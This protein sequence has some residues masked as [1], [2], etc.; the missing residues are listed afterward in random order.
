MVFAANEFALLVSRFRGPGGPAF[1]GELLAQL[2]QHVAARQ[3][4]EVE[5]TLDALAV[6]VGTELCRDDIRKVGFVHVVDAARGWVRKGPD[7]WGRP[8]GDEPGGDGRTFRHGHAVNC[9]KNSDT[10]RGA[11]R[12]NSDL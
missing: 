1:P 6:H 11:R 9:Q 3:L 7:A 2:V 10:V 12:V 4:G 8:G 5:S